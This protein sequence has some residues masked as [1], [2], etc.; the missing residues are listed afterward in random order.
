M[1]S[2]YREFEKDFIDLNNKLTEIFLVTSLG[3]PEHRA[4]SMEDVIRSASNLIKI[5]SK[6]APLIKYFLCNDVLFVIHKGLIVGKTIDKPILV[7][8]ADFVRKLCE[9][10]GEVRECYLDFLKKVIKIYTKQLNFGTK[11]LICSGIQISNLD[12]SLEILQLIML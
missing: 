10:L 2:L 5:N 12:F 1:T 11:I 9:I 4:K 6:I 7:F 3:C 8:V